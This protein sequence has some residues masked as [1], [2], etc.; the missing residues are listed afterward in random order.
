MNICNSR[1]AFMS[2]QTARQFLKYIL[3]LLVVGIN[4]IEKKIAV[5]AA[6]QQTIENKTSTQQ[7]Y[8]HN[9]VELYIN[10]ISRQIG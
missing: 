10:I 2:C 4:K 6:S 3:I 1:P 8:K 5:P 9:I 7:I